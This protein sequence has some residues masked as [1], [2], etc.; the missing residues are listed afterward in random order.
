[1]PTIDQINTVLLDWLEPA[2]IVLGGL[3]LGTII[4]VI[5]L[6]RLAQWAK[7]TT[8]QGDDV[9][10]A[11]LRRKF[12]LWGFL[13]GVLVAVNNL[14]ADLVRDFQ[15]QP[16]AIPFITNALTVLFVLSLTVVVAN[17]SAG[18]LRVSSHAHARPALSLV[19]NIVRVT[20][21]IIGALIVLH[22]FNIEISPALAALGVTGLAVSLA[23]QSTLT[24]L[25]RAS[26]FSPHS[27]S[28]RGTT[29]GSVAA[30]RATSPILA[31]APRRS[32]TSATT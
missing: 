32:S 26:R 18:M 23:L 17:V 19:T 14:P 16:E 30:R 1:M 11:A 9:I 15:Q 29:S 25:V 27:R 22:I 13:G 21:F 5:V 12:I 3:V 20:I 4:E 10:I 6:V 7:R 28:S 31:G 24:D 2:G 8:W